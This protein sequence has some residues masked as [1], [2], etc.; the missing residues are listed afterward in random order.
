[1]SERIAATKPPPFSAVAIQLLETAEFHERAS[2]A[3]VNHRFAKVHD[4]RAAACREAITQ[5]EALA[6]RFRNQTVEL[7]V[8]LGKLT[9][10]AS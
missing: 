9:A 8:A 1:M 6:D 4:Q 3:W 7:H 5:Y 10:A 2:K